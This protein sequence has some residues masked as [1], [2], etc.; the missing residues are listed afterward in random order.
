LSDASPADFVLRLGRTFR[1]ARVDAG[2][3]QKRLADAAGVARTGI[4]MFERGARVPSVY[5]CKAVANALG[6]SLQELIA[7]AERG[8]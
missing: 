3:S 2:L 6:K 4:I 7:E 8:N 5:F 1:E